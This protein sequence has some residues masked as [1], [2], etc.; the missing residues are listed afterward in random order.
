[1]LK[2]EIQMSINQPDPIT[3]FA[4][5]QICSQCFI[6]SLTSLKYQYNCCKC[7]YSQF[8]LLALIN[9]TQHPLIRFVRCFPV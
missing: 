8:Y 6:F 1:M 2:I 9:L 4:L 5:F 7:I 3:L